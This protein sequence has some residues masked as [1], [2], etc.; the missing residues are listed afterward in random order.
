MARINLSHFFIGVI[1]L[2]CSLP[3]EAFGQTS[4]LKGTV[5]DASGSPLIGVNVV[6]KGT[7]N[8][9]ITDIDGGF[10]I[11]V[12][13]NATI[14][15]TY[16]GYA[17][18]EIVWSGKGELNV[19]L[20][21][22]SELLDEVVVVGYGTQKKVNLT[23]A[24]S[25]VSGD[26]L[27]NR[28]LPSLTRGLQ[29]M[30]P[31]LNIR[32]VD[33]SPT[34]SATFNVRGETSI[35]SGGSALVLIDGIEGDPSMVNPNDIE[36]VSVL[37]DAASSAIYGSR[38][39]FG[40][41]LITTKSAKKD[42]IQV[43]ISS[44]YSLNQRTVTPK[45]I[46][47]GYE[48]AKNFADA[49]S[50]W[51]DYNSFPISVNNIYPF[52]M[53]YL[54]ALKEHAENPNLPEVVFNEE[55]GRYEYFR[56][57]DW[58]KI[59]NKDN[60]FSNEHSASISGGSDRVKFLTSGRYYFQDGIFNYNSDKFHKYN[61]RL[62]GDIKITDW[63]L[64]HE[65]AE[66][67]NYNY[68]YPMFSDGDGNIWR[69]FE[70][71]GYPMAVLYNPDGTYTHT[72]VYTGVAAYME[73]K[74]RSEQKYNDFRTT[75]GL[76]AR[77]F[78][79]SLVL[80][81]D[82][83]YTTKSDKESRANNFIDYSIAPGDIRRF[84]RSL[85]RYYN[86]EIIYQGANITGEYSKIFNDKHDFDF[87]LGYNVEKY[88]EKKLYL[89][90]D[91]IL[92]ENKPDFNL[93]DGLNYRINGGGKEWSFLGL[94]YR[95]A[96]NY[97][98][99]YLLETNGRYDGSSK[100]PANQRFGFFPS[101][102]AGWRISEEPFM[103]GAKKWLDNLKLRA[104]YGSLGN[105]NVDPYRFLET[106]GVGRTGVIIEGVQQTYTSMPDVI[107]EGLTWETANTLNFGVDIN[108]I[109]KFELIFDWYKRNTKDM[110]TPGKPL[111]SVFGTA[112]PYG[113]FADMT[114]KGWE[115]ALTWR[116]S[117]QLGNKPFSYSITGSLWDS[118]SFITRFN[119]EE[120]LLS[121]YYV[122]Q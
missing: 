113:N 11:N 93:L 106:M 30:I 52:S 56:N 31:N 99:R 32:M 48:W 25:Q 61:L 63:L 46:T 18:Q 122:G 82:Y 68:G 15:V 27:E 16:I 102:S 101:V 112:V 35:G 78:D 105:G 20:R 28:P 55:K 37:K 2:F 22:D 95:L 6:E 88:A 74:N 26:V 84:G 34:R 23:G 4:T 1:L 109:N 81:G 98:G 72:A 44:N 45:V 39:A 51:Y 80:K 97:K 121:T 94:F 66:L 115:L 76:T 83:T 36:S 90:R 21:E 10:S 86:T 60:I 120:K 65:N 33:G 19:I 75:T 64:F 53:E 57:T 13:P 107:P 85:L 119:N 24:V 110:F 79:N 111:P 38:A 92:D 118:R 59:I 108:L 114:T 50:A 89:S 69:Q 91:G 117:F 42:K 96:Y 47:N 17:D 40:V 14:T 8:G 70:H 62:K 100:F 5:K 12:K 58:Y 104:S 103:S 43:N 71:Q 87:L 54:E 67:N 3:I 9:T 49:F 77:L 73:N 116:D 41:V 29:G 7:T